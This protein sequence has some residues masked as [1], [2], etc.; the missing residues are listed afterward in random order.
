MPAPL[1]AEYTILCLCVANLIFLS[2][3]SPAFLSYASCAHASRATALLFRIL[4]DPSHQCPCLSLLSA[5]CQFC[6]MPWPIWSHHAMPLRSI[7]DQSPATAVLLRSA[8]IRCGACHFYA[9]PS[10]C[11]PFHSSTSPFSAFPGLILSTPCIAKADRFQSLPF[12]CFDMLSVSHPP[13]VAAPPR[14]PCPCSASHCL[15]THFR[16]R[17]SPCN[18]IPASGPASPV[19]LRSDANL[20]QSMSHHRLRK[21]ARCIRSPC[22]SMGCHAIP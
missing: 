15:T 13:R 19:R 17:S 20:C 8:L 22:Q 10:P 12:L 16:C 18:A 5:A 7:S 2:I 21:S 9:N 11:T 1:R 3:S 6:A 14:D 4:A